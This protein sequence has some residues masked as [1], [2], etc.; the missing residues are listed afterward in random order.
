L[1]AF[2]LNLLLYPR[3]MPMNLS[4]LEL[5]FD[6]SPLSK[7]DADELKLVGFLKYVFL[8]GAGGGAFFF[9]CVPLFKSLLASFFYVCSFV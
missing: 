1:L 2:F 5:F 9:E 7:E 8:C 6:F 3:G 4:L